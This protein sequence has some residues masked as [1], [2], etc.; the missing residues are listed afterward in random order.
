[1]P[2]ARIWEHAVQRR[3][4]ERIKNGKVV[5]SEAHIDYVAL[6]GLEVVKHE[7]SPA[8]IPAV[9]AAGSASPRN[10]LGDHAIVTV[11]AQPKTA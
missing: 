1:M 9:F 4:I 8:V 11:L 5:F 6:R 7:T 3:L 2:R 10:M